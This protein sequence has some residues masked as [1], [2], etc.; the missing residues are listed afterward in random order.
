[1]EL[2]N[3]NFP[4]VVTGGAGFLGQN[5]IKYLCEIG[6]KC[7]IIDQKSPSMSEIKDA[8]RDKRVRLLIVDLLK[9]SWIA[10][11]G[12]Y[13][14]DKF[15]LVHLAAVIETTKEVGVQT[16]KT[17]E[18]HCVS[19]MNSFESWGKKLISA[20]YTS[21][22]EVYGV[23]KFLPIKET[24]ETNP[25]NVYGIGKLLTENYLRVFCN[26]I[27][28]PL[29]I[30]RLSHIYGPGEWLNKAIPNFIKNCI[31]GN[32]HK[33]FGGGM[34]V[35]EFVNVRD[36][37]YAIN[38]SLNRKSEGIFNIAG[39]RPLNIRQILDLVQRIYGSDLPVIELPAD[40]PPLDLSFDLTLAERE[41]GYKPKVTL[42]DGLKEEIDWF[43]SLKSR[44]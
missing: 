42:E 7:I 36:A 3:N 12:T 6:K 33:L 8:V 44:R 28:I 11:I 25:F 2:T 9:K 1:M 19:S 17:I 35:R 18:Y 23:P 38:L 34:D 20:C 5:V 24:L 14:P 13:L 30:L 15:H 40:R 16:R 27:G 26:S 37:A 21:S 39:G 31:A 22:W 29:T 32:P 41:L 4:V 43:I 10:E